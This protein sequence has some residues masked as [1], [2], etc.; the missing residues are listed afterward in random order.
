MSAPCLKA[1]V[2]AAGGGGGRAL[3]DT[4]LTATKGEHARVWTQN[5]PGYADRGGEVSY[6]ERRA[7]LA[8][9]VRQAEEDELSRA[10]G[11]RGRKIGDGGGRTLYRLTYSFHED[12]G[13][14]KVRET[15]SEHQR[16]ALP[17]AY[18]LNS[19]HRNTG[20]VH[21]HSVVLA[22]Q[23]DGGKLHLDWR[24]YRTLDE[25]W[26]RI[27][28][29]EFGEHFE[30][31]HLAKKEERREHRR[32]AREAKARGEPPPP[33]PEREAQRRNQLREKIKTS[34]RESGLAHA[35]QQG[36]TGQDRRADA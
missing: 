9:F 26:A 13:D 19:I 34:G 2:G 1:V 17:K 23:T 31:E 29:R 36:V 3:Y 11:A 30:R 7:D 24:E 25:K 10:A 8:E 21:V 22:R 33:R 18:I 6:K 35:D 12:P 14:E 20:H 32:L 27:Y 5:V 16:V 4:R 28:G 15:V